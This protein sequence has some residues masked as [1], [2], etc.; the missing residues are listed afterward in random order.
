[1]KKFLLWFTPGLILGILLILG[2]GKAIEVTSTNEF[3]MSCHIHPAADNAWK[4]SVHYETKSGYRVGCADCHLPP[5]GD[6]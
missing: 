2:G 1:M 3:C 4:K 5:K 6:G